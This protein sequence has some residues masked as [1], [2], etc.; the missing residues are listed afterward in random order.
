MPHNLVT[1]FKHI[2][3]DSLALTVKRTDSF[4]VCQFRELY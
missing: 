3:R 4:Q 2:F 1:T